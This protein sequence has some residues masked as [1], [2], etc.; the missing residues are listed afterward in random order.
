MKLLYKDALVGECLSRES[1]IEALNS[2]TEYD[3]TQIV[4]D[5]LYGDKTL[6]L[7]PWLK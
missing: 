4:D 3:F 5:Y 1:L 2:L 6:N 7:D